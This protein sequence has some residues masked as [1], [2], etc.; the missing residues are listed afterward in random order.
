M[1]LLGGCTLSPCPEATTTPMVAAVL[2]DAGVTSGPESV[3]GEAG[4]DIAP[5]TVSPGDRI[6]IHGSGFQPEEAIMVVV[7][8]PAQSYLYG[9]QALQNGEYVQEI[10]LLETLPVG[11]VITIEATGQDSGRQLN[12]AIET[13]NTMES[14]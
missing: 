8:A 5:T 2:P 12:G 14:S 6:S 13:I 4:L 9:S 7:Q 10:V 1:L 3:S 11:T